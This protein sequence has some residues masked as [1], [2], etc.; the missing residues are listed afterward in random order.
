MSATWKRSIK[1]RLDK[2]TSDGDAL[3]RAFRPRTA[4]LL[5]AFQKLVDVGVL[6]TLR[7]SSA[8]ANAALSN[9]TTKDG[10]AKAPK[11]AASIPLMAL[12]PDWVPMRN[13]DGTIA[14]RG[15]LWDFVERLSRFRREG[16]K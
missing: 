8:A 15:R 9:K 13:E 11:K 2:P 1:V 14:A 12:H 10:R 5:N 3:T 6:L 4:T 16:K 7:S